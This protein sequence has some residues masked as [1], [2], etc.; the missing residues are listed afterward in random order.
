MVSHKRYPSH[1]AV[2]LPLSYYV[3]E[4][5]WRVIEAVRKSARKITWLA[6]RGWAITIVGVILIIL[7]LMAMMPVPVQYQI[8]GD[9]RNHAVSHRIH[10]VQLGTE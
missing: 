10:N 3:S 2:S 7:V 9:S 4:A 8:I 6:I 5:G 1:R